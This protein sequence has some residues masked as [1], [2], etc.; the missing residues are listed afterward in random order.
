MLLHSLIVIGFGHGI[1]FIIFFDVFAIPHLFT[2]GIEINFNSNYEDRVMDVAV[3]SAVGKILLILGLLFK[4]KNYK[5]VLNL[6]GLSLLLFSVCY[7]TYGNWSY[8]SLFGISFSFS[9]PF[10]IYSLLFLATILVE[11]K[12]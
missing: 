10:L 3:F 7:L 6:I 9:I 8:S 4:Q 1:G 2:N 12:K 5:I 11:I